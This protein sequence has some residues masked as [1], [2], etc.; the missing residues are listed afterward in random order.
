M[1]CAGHSLGR[2][3][4]SSNSNAAL[5]RTK[6]SPVS[7]AITFALDPTTVTS[8]TSRTRLAAARAS[9]RIHR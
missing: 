9:H 5:R 8:P 7:A 2:L 1:N 3:C 6:Q 4:Q